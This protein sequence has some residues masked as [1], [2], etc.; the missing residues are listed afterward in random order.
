MTLNSQFNLNSDNLTNLVKACCVTFGLIISFYGIRELYNYGSLNAY[1]HQTEASQNSDSSCQKMEVPNNIYV[2]VSGAVA[3]TGIYQVPEDSLISEVIASAGGFLNTADKNYINKNLNLAK[4]ISAGEK[5]YIPFIEE[6]I[7]AVLSKCIQTLEV[8]VG[9]NNDVNHVAKVEIISIN[10][11]TL[12][13][14]ETLDGIGQ[15]RAEAIV[16]NRPY[17]N[18]R[19]LVEKNVISANLFTQIEENISL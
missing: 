14:L 18:L 19:E 3:K 7:D 16:S 6:K 5:I 1:S 10:N 4:K 17:Q 12:V 13:E 9:A 8:D 11:A 15:K 2:D